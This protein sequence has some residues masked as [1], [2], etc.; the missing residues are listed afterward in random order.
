M[1]TSASFFFILFFICTCVTLNAQN[2]PFPQSVNYLGKHIKPSN[3]TSS[4]R[5]TQIQNF[6]NQWITAYF[7]E[8]CSANQAYIKYVPN[9]KQ[10]VSE[11][12]GYGMMLTVYMAGYDSDAKRKFDALFRYFKAYPSSIDNRLMAWKQDNCQS[13]DGG[14]SA[15]DGDIDIAYALLLAHDQWGSLGNIDYLLEAKLIIDGIEAEEINPETFLPTLG[16]WT[17]PSST[18]YYHATRS[19]DFITDHFRSF[20]SV[21]NSSL[22]NN[23][24]DACYNAINHI[25]VNY[26]S[27][28][29]LVP[30]F[31]IDANSNMR[32]AYANFL[33]GNYDGDYFYNACRTPWRLATDYLLFNETRAEQ[34]LKPFNNW[35]Y[36][37]SS[38]NPNN[39]SNGYRLNGTAIYQFNDPAFVSA[40]VVSAMLDTNKQA[41]LNSLYA[42]LIQQNF[43]SS[44]YY[45][46]SIKLLSMLVISGHYWAPG[47]SSAN[48]PV[49]NFTSS[50][51]S[52]LINS[53]I[54]FDASQSSDPNQENLSYFWDFGDG[55][56]DT[57][58]ISNHS[59]T[60]SGNYTVKLTVSNQSALSSTKSKSITIFDAMPE[61]YFISPQNTEALDSGQVNIRFYAN[62]FNGSVDSVRLTI[63]AQPISI[64]QI[65]ATEY[66]SIWQAMP[67]NYTLVASAYD[68]DANYVESTIDVSV[69]SKAS[70][71]AILYFDITSDWGNGYCANMILENISDDDIND[72]SLNFDLNDDVYDNW[73]SN[74]SNVGDNYTVTPYN[75]LKTIAPNSSVSFG[76]CATYQ[77]TIFEACNVLL[78]GE[79]TVQSIFWGYDT[80][81]CDTSTSSTPCM[82]QNLDYSDFENDWGYWY[83]G[84]L[85]CERSALFS[86]DA[87]DGAYSIRLMG[88]SNSSLMYS[89][90]INLNNAEWVDVSFQFK[91]MMTNINDELILEVSNDG[92]SFTPLKVYKN[93]VDFLNN[94]VVSDTLRWVNT[95]NYNT[96]VF[97]IRSASKSLLGH[98]YIDNINLSACSAQKIY[99]LLVGLE[100]M[101]GFDVSIFPN[102]A[103]DKLHIDWTYGR[104]K[105][106]ILNNQLHPVGQYIIN[107]GNSTIDISQL[108]SA[109]YILKIEF[110]GEVL[111]KRIIK[112]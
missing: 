68:N 51:D 27:N 106:E 48:N 20:S 50:S 110:A 8:D 87:I 41:W 83:D 11:A 58:K 85:F 40:Y 22:W 79:K 46:N 31:I 15:T 92:G 14:D 45:E 74:W 29:G 16:D 70:N 18:N 63:N 57:S 34:A 76:Y 6:Y 107:A 84:G 47:Q 53:T 28:T 17:H 32:P 101:D 96:L 19:S 4:D 43:S 36:N 108:P 111:H 98:F 72:W 88:N 73:E 75:H 3:Y 90:T 99:A 2:K 23:V 61:L 21:G 9:A 49:A 30:D 112:Q 100:E 37:A 94:S 67:G 39:L 56:T 7:R 38:A 12:M 102:P 89:K 1:K 62:D 52:A 64:N 33:E 66:E 54:N 80:S 91:A 10:T 86:G 65:S 78:N 25:Q 82:F 26:S 35:L 77:N 55:S 97:R 42:H 81:N 103:H 13:V 95:S 69:N 93:G 109:M 71:E 105:V 104:A 60:N 5:I 24:L 59:Y 44:K